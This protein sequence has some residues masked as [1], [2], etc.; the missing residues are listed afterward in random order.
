MAR[1]GR[2]HTQYDDEGCG[3]RHEPEACRDALAAQLAEIRRRVEQLTSIAANYDRQ[4][5]AV[6]RAVEASPHETTVEAVERYV[7]L[8]ALLSGEHATKEKNDA[9]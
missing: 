2:C 8:A 4:V 1:C 6:R 5:Q 3:L 7:S 9:T